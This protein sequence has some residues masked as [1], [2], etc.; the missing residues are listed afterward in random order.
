MEAPVEQLCRQPAVPMPV[1]SVR[2]SAR[3]LQ[4]TRGIDN[5]SEDTAHI[6]NGPRPNGTAQDSGGVDVGSDYASPA[7][8]Q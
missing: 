1:Q 4:A 5:G 8:P 2:Q 7:A 6:G 3:V